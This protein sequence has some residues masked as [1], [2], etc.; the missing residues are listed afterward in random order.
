MNNIDVI[1]DIEQMINKAIMKTFFFIIVIFPLVAF[2]QIQSKKESLKVLADGRGDSIVLRWAP[3]S[4]VVW[5]L[6][7]KY[8]Y[9]IERFLF[10][11]NGK[12]VADKEKKLLTPA[13]LKPWSKSETDKMNSDDG[14][15][16]AIAEILYSDE[17]QAKSTKEDLASIINTKDEQERRYG[18]ALLLSDFSAGA[19]TVAGLRFVDK[20]I[21]KNCRYIYR[22]QVNSSPKSKTVYESGVVMIDAKE[23]FKKPVIRDVQVSFENKKA[24]VTWPLFL[25][26][27][28]YSGYFIERSVDGK[29]FTTITEQPYVQ[30]SEQANT[31]N[32]YFVDSLADNN[33]TFY[34][35]VKGI[36]PFAEIG[37]PSA[38]VSGKGK[39][40]LVLSA[41]IN[42]AEVLDNKR[43]KLAWNIE[44]QQANVLNK[45]IISRATNTAGPYTDIAILN[46]VARNTWEDQQPGLNN[47]YRL[48]IIDKD[49]NTTFSLPY[50]APLEDDQSPATPSNILGVAAKTG[51][52]QLYWNKNQ[53]E[54][55]LGYRIFRSNAANEELMEVTKEILTDTVFV[56]SINL[57]TLTKNIYYSVIAVDKRFNTSP[58]SP[59]VRLQR[60]D[61]IPPA[62]VVFDKVESSDKGVTIAFTSSISNDVERYE[63]YRQRS[64]NKQKMADFI[65]KQDN[66]SYIDTAKI[67]N[68]SYKYFVLVKDSAGNYSMT[69]S[70]PVL[71]NHQ[72]NS[73]MGD[74]KYDVDRTGKKIILKWT[75]KSSA[76]KSYIIYKGKNQ[77][78][79]TYYKS[80]PANVNSF[81]DTNL[82][83]NNTYQYQ[84]LPIYANGTKG[85]ISSKLKI[86]Y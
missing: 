38:V 35:R 1:V 17:F 28:V 48:K 80:I 49:S 50:Y 52:V 33:T 3:M 18:F 37:E 43:V 11:R 19:A 9:T 69:E 5:K 78:P 86:K 27:G 25:Y 82:L 64:G 29:N 2:P 45:I 74:V 57:H 72:Q 67:F 47:Y 31:G 46:D 62:P 20:N 63:L 8:G 77:E 26:E 68:E 24:I 55:L 59:L 13:P 36:T 51:K 58:Y 32:A 41:T 65:G 56:D 42:K 53:E 6:G 22:I 84:I 79:L 4:P 76:V 10:S 23:T 70:K 21:E 81:E 15:A 61:T 44:A 16:E 39:E 73:V 40:D 30:A 54:D 7:N 66:I 83:I 75:L 34:Y 60:P 14:Y 85:I 12:V 71:I